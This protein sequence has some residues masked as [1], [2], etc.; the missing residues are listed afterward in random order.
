[1]TSLYYPFR[2]GR[3][4]RTR[5]PTALRDQPFAGSEGGMSR[6]RFKGS[7]ERVRDLE[8]RPDEVDPVGA[9]DG[10]EHLGTHRA[11]Q[12]LGEILE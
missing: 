9:R 2:G 8:R 6:S 7:S 10:I 5:F 12:E 11:G 4:E 1:M 3:P